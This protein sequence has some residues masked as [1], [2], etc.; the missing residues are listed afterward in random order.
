MPGTTVAFDFGHLSEHWCLR[1]EQLLARAGRDIGPTTAAMVA[2]GEHNAWRESEAAL[3]ERIHEFA[4]WLESQPQRAIA[5]VGHGDFWQAFT[6]RVFGR[7]VR[8]PNCGWVSFEGPMGVGAVMTLG[9]G[10]TVTKG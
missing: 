1:H 3:D 4:A 10:A 6:G 2:I 8:L 9:P 7:A 5:V